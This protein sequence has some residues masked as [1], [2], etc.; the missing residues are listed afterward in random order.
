MIHNLGEFG[1]YLVSDGSSRPYRCKIRGASWTHL[2]GVE[3][4][5]K[6]LFMADAVAI[7]GNVYFFIYIKKY[8]NIIQNNNYLK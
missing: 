2:A 7:V 6:G 5:T 8:Y 4:L 1:V 3:L